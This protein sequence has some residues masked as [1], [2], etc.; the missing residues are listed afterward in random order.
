MEFCLVPHNK[1]RI[2]LKKAKAKVSFFKND[3]IPKKDETIPM[4]DQKSIGLKLMNDS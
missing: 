4:K 1:T 2:F 3:K